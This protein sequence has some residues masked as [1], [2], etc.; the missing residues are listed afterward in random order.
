MRRTEPL[1]AVLA[2]IETD[3]LAHVAMLDRSKRPGEAQVIRG[4]ARRIG[5][6][7]ILAETKAPRRNLHLKEAA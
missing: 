6:A 7:A 2:E 4:F 5:C 1:P 3:M